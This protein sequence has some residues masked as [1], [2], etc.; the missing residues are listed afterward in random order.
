ML[1]QLE[2]QINTSVK[3]ILHDRPLAMLAT[4][5]ACTSVYVSVYFCTRATS[6][7]SQAIKRR[8]HYHKFKFLN[9][10]S[11][12]NAKLIVYAPAQC[13]RFIKSPREQLQFIH[14][15]HDHLISGAANQSAPRSCSLTSVADQNNIHSNRVK[16][17]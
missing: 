1:Q 5:R 7:V 6:W 4:R 11:N 17:V 13:Y 15:R 9:Y 10:N 2:Y 12:N 3:Q 8:F 16:Y 14:F